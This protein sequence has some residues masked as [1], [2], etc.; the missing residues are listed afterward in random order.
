[1]PTSDYPSDIV[2]LGF[3][4]QNQ[5]AGSTSARNAF[6]QELFDAYNQLIVDAWNQI[7]PPLAEP[8]NEARA[9]QAIMAHNA[10]GTNREQALAAV[11]AFQII[12]G[13]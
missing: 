8:S 11:G 1:V 3:F 6:G 2:G 9:M 12:R 13:L 5:Q 4:V 10:P 7:A